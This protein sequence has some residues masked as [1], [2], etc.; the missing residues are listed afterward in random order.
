MRIKRTLARIQIHGDQ[1]ITFRIFNAKVIKEQIK[2]G[3]VKEAQTLTA[4][5][6]RITRSIRDLKLD[7]INL[8]ITHTSVYHKKNNNNKRLF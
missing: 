7:N 6:C 5:Y 3:G 2:R 8:R 1:N 4:L